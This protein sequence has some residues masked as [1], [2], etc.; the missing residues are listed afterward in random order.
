MFPHAFVI[1]VAPAGWI[2]CRECV[3]VV[4]SVAELKN[5]RFDA[6]VPTHK[7]PRSPARYSSLGWG[8]WRHISI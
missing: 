1:P 4:R 7:R 2:R 6:V 5:M 3:G 8:L